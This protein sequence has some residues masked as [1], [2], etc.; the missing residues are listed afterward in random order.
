MT[1]GMN[2][3]SNRDS[4]LDR[5]AAA[6]GPVD[7]LVIGGGIVGS[8][9]ARDAAMRGLSTLL[10]DRYDFAFGTSSRSSRL[11]HGGL[12][13]LAQGRV[14]L[15]HEASTEKV[16]LSK[17]AP[18]LASPLPFVFPTYKRD[19]WPRWKL[20]VGVKLYD[21]LCGG[22]NL[23]KSR[24][25]SPTAAAGLLPG[26]RTDQLTGGV[27]YY[28][29]L[30]NDAR[31]VL[32][33]LR[34][35]AAAGA[36]V[37][38]YLSLTSAERRGDLW[39]CHLT[40][41]DGGRRLTVQART[42]VNAAGA[43]ATQLPS[44]R[45]RLRLTKGV[46][47]V[48]EKHRLPAAEAVVMTDG[49]R[50][51]FVIPW[52]DRTILGTTDTDYD[53]PLESPDCTA[54]DVAYVLKITNRT[55]PAAG[56]TPAD[57]ISAWSGLRP[58][59]ADP[60]GK[61]SDVSRAHQI[62][63]GEPGW[64]DVAGG[65]LTTYRLMAEQAV[66]RVATYLGRTTPACRTAAEP[67]LT[68]AA[69]SG[70]P[71]AGD[72]T[73]ADAGFSGVVPPAV[74]ES[75]VAHFCRREWGRHLDDVMI[76]RTSWR[77]YHRDH[78]EVAARVADWMAAALGWTP[79]RTAAELDRYREMTAPLAATWVPPSGVDD[80]AAAAASGASRRAALAVG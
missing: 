7:V 24:G 12:R 45:V 48:V 64:L 10:V 32:D 34:S 40:D 15:V 53:G 29:G 2:P 36:T 56:L 14:G 46:H 37:L 69:N 51:L 41:A 18:H 11:L 8:G 74:S 27:R 42:V 39:H 35:A 17:I 59:I 47:V 19:G 25:L 73:A 20:R 9:V 16:T 58:L 28:D 72:A 3:T 60:K 62:L 5:L 22:R 38:N 55:F 33:T 49:T 43:W 63:D 23:G 67:I 4:Q 6:D 78:L 61:P 79:E 52:G 50:I 13:Y 21:L 44:S 26:L 70:S 75:A 71:P 54:E 76:R 66:D 68:T 80:P 57:V 30:T 65:K 31:L 77:Y 1:S